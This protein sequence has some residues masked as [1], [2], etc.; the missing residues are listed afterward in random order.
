MPLRLKSAI[1]VFWLV[2]AMPA[3][4][5][6]TPLEDLPSAAEASAPAQAAGDYVIGPLDTL[7]IF[8]WRNPELSAD[9]PV[10]PDG[11]ISVPLIQDIQAAGKTPRELSGDL[12]VAL[13]EYLQD[14]NV[15]VIV[16]QFVGPFGQ[17]VRVV[18]EATRPQAVP[19]R[20]DMTVLD[21]MIAVEGLTP[22]AAGNRAVIVRRVGGEEQRYR[23][24]LNDLLDS[25][26]MTA[27]A[28][29]MP[30]DVL[31]VPESWF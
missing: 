21:L 12:E 10:R 16:N 29:L 4:I 11:R 20:E 19:Y 2:F 5:A 15:T 8:V 23:V 31:I 26:D 22:Y 7:S 14:P 28:R 9:V 30:G 24:R 13:S 3:F 18:G 17:Q 27:N 1:A 25:G 6:C